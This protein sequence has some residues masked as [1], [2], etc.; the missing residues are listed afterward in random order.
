MKYFIDKNN[1][2]FAYDDEQVLQGYGKDLEEILSS[3]KEDG[4]IYA[5]YKNI[6]T[7]HELR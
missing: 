6:G 7:W 5:G 4:T 1:N 2:I 3:I